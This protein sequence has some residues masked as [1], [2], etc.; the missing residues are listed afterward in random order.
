MERAFYF[1]NMGGTAEVNKDFCPSNFTVTDVF[2]C[3]TIYNQFNT[4]KKKG[5]LHYGKSTTQ[6]LSYGGSNAKKMV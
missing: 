6:N 4:L 5:V 3:A 1:V 2:F